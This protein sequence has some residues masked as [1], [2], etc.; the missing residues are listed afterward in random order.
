MILEGRMINIMGDVFLTISIIGFTLFFLY[1]L[2]LQVTQI[3]ALFYHKDNVSDEVSINKNKHLS[4]FAVL[5]CAHNEEPVIAR[6]IESIKALKYNRE[7][8]DIFVVAHNCLDNTARLAEDS[9]AKVFVLS[10]PGAGRKADALNYGIKEIRKLETSYDAFAFFDAD[11]VVDPMFLSCADQVLASGADMVQGKYGSY[12]Y[13]D[14]AVSE[15]SGALWLQTFHMQAETFKRAGLPMLSYGTG[16]VLRTSAISPEGWPTVSLVEDFEMSIM[17]ALSGKKMIGEGSMITYAEQPVRFKDA[18]E[19]RKRWVVGDMQ[20]LRRYFVPV[21]KAIPQKGICAVKILVDLLLNVALVGFSVGVMFLI[22]FAFL[23]GISLSDF[24]LIFAIVV[25]GY[26]FFMGI[27]SLIMFRK[28]GMRARK[29]IA[30]LLLFPFW[31]LLSS[32]L[33][34]YALFVKDIEWK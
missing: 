3:M 8:Y 32:V 13:H 31:I 22:L 20:C 14:N 7:M 23:S 29:N 1:F 18:L 17:L 16:F 15:L 25:G 26:W 5:I 19:Q 33:A 24:I 28:E 34:C 10:E 21:V 11:N 30:T 12:N 2:W 6:I 9:G 27:Q 4:R